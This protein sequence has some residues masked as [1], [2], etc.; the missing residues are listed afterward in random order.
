MKKFFM[1]VSI[2]SS[3]L[4]A[5]NL[6]TASMQELEKI[7]GI[8][9]KKAKAI[10]EYRKTHKIKS[11]DELKNIKGFDKSTISNVKNNV[12]AKKHRVKK[13]KNKKNLKE[14]KEEIKK[15][16]KAKKEKIKK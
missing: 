16:L 5:L 12:I 10:I 1:T 11:A 3:S 13:L 9:P 2:I 15:K 7:K 14:K 8:G 6:N 4:F